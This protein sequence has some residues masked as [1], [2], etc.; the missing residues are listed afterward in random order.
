[1]NFGDLLEVGNGIW[2]V[3]SLW[4]SSFLLFHLLVVRVQRKIS[5]NRFLFKLPFSMQLAVGTL[6][7]AVAV[8]L[9][10]TVLWWARYR[11]SD[12]LNLFMPA[13]VTYLFGT[14]LGIVGFLCILR[15]ISQPSFG[16]WPWIGALLSVAVYVAWWVISLQ[17]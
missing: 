4:L 13:S 16:R 10:R 1:M 8:L 7:V 15:T 3:L 5:W 11:H 14:S 9:T 17:F 2:A 12:D 6:V